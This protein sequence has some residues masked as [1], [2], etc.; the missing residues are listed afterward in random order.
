MAEHLP[1]FKFAF[2]VR[3]R[4]TNLSTSWRRS[5][6]HCGWRFVVKAVKMRLAINMPAGDGSHLW[7][8]TN[9]EM[10]KAAKES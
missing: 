5:A 6:L 4:S 3:V 8:R 2:S 7:P 9:V 1:F 10:M